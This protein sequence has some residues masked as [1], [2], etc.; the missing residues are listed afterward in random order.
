MKMQRGELVGFH[1]CYGYD[2]DKLTKTLTVN[3]EEKKVIQYIF[4]RYVQGAGTT[5]IAKELT[6]AYFINK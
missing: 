5:M 1:G 4:G 3:E 6:E 2:Y